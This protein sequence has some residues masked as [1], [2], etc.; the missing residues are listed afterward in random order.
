[1]LGLG[2]SFMLISRHY[3]SQCDHH[4]AIDVLLRRRRHTPLAPRLIVAAPSNYSELAFAVI[5][6]LGSDGPEQIGNS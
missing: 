2:F 4:D 5:P 3:L 1:M 6:G